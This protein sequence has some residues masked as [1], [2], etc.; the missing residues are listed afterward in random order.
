MSRSTDCCPP[1]STPHPACLLP[2]YKQPKLEIKKDPKGVV[3]VPG[4]TVVDNISSARELMD[5]IESGLARRRVSSTQ[6]RRCWGVVGLLKVMRWSRGT[7]S[8]GQ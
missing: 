7:A 1:C 4:A 3:T 8:S 2:Q 6:V 5:V